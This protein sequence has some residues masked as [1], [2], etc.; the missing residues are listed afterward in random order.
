M[1]PM[2]NIAINAARAAGNLIVRYFDRVDRLTITKKGFNEFVTEVDK[3]AEQ[4]IVDTLLRSYPHHGILGEEGGHRKGENDFLWI[5]DP[6][7]GTTNY[8]HGFPQF[9]VSIALSYRDRL[10]QAVVYDPL[11]EELFT[12]TRGEG[13]KLNNRRIRVSRCNSLDDAL[14][15]TGFPCRN[16]EH[17]DAYLSIFKTFTTTSA[18]I[19]RPGSA[20]LDLA[21]V[22]AGRFDGFWEFGLA[23][24]DMAAGALLVQEAGG[25]VSGLDGR[26]DYLKSGN[27]IAGNPKIHAVMMHSLQPYGRFL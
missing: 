14:L 18:G 13:A 17:I 24:W 9:S 6:L 5:I 4:I 25:I 11:R 21:S 27:I 1:H 16:L 23:V 20:A 22:A 7:D 8:I 26:D 12:A 15:G 3:Q 2:L 19:R 10:E